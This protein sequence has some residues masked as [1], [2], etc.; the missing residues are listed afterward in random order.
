MFGV[1]GIPLPPSRTLRQ[2]RGVQAFQLIVETHSGPQVFG[3]IPDG[4]RTST[5]AM[6]RRVLLPDRGMLFDYGRTLRCG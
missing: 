2:R 6:F 1:L 5:R 4:C 3:R